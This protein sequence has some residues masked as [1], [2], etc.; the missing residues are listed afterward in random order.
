M[1]E[2]GIEERSNQFAR[3]IRGTD[4][5]PGVF[6]DHASK[7]LAAV[8]AFFPDDFRSLD[9]TWIVDQQRSAFTGNDVFGFME[10]EAPKVS[11]ATERLAFPRGLQGLCRILH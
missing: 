1:L 4:V 6:V 5:D 8:R 11:N 10:T 2:L 7:E 3:Q 9:Q